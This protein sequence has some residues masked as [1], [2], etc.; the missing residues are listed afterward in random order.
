MRDKL[1]RIAHQIAVESI[2]TG[3]QIE[4]I[5]HQHKRRWA[6]VRELSDNRLNHSKALTKIATLA[7]WHKRQLAAIG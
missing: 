2:E 5:I 6:I 4:Y 7:V 3:D 1:D